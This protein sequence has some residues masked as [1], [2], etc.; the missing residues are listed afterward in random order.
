VDSISQDEDDLHAVART[1]YDLAKGKVQARDDAGALAE[2]LWCFDTGMK[3][4]PSY[5]GVRLSFLLGEIQRLGQGYPPALEALRQR[6]DDAEKALESSV[7]AI[8]DYVSL[9]RVLKEEARSLATLDLFPPAS[10]ARTHLAKW[11]FDPLLEAR[12]YTE[13]A[14]AF[15]VN[16][17]RT[18][19]ENHP[20]PPGHEAEGRRYLTRL[21]ARAIEAWAGAGRVDDAQLGIG[22]LLAYDGSDEAKAELRAH[23]VRAG[24]PELMP[25]TS[26]S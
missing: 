2:F 10:P 13:A 3:R 11:L 24:H 12:R 22:L 6:R 20:V 23:L 18:R 21:A 25:D 26:P 1:R 5:F 16:L 17:F 14:D 19:F 15:S 8:P 4:S 9:N 7:E